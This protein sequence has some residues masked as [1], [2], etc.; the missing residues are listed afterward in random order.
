MACQGLYTMAYQTGFM[1]V[2]VYNGMPGII[3][4]GIPDWIYEGECIQWHTTLDL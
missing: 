4:N 2:S 3:Y 1:K